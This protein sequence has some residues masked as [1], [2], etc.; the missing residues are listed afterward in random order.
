[1]TTGNTTQI[2]S[3]E[4]DQGRLT[5]SG[6]PEDSDDAGNF[7]AR[8]T[9][10]AQM[11][12]SAFATLLSG[13]GI[14]VTGQPAQQT[15]PAGAQKLA[16]VSS[17]TVGQLSDVMLTESNNVIAENLARHVAIALGYPA[18]FA[19][20]AAA[21]T[22]TVRA[23]G[24]TT[25]FSMVDGSGLSPLDQIAP[26]SLATL[27]QA[28][29]AKPKLH[30]VLV[31]LPV[32]GFSGTLSPG[33]SVFGGIGGPGLGAVRAKTGNLDTVAALAGLIDDKGGRLL[34]FAIMADQ[35]TNLDQAGSAISA[36]ATQLAGL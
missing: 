1:V 9:D 23:L 11:A 26:A 24:V 2:V 4:V 5:P 10:P 33:G 25:T 34:A 31:G 36:A 16:S 21:V 35:V 20:S 3:L 14:K 13:D 19:G 30:A 28:I 18:T 32:A 27:L 6:A 8:A 17:P 12:A 22:A 29:V 15:A 7:T